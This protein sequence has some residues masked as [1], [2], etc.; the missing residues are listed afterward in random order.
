MRKE[1]EIEYPG[2]FPPGFFDNVGKGGASYSILH[3]QFSGLHPEVESGVLRT[4][5]KTAG[6]EKP[7][8]AM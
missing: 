1:A 2:G 5:I 7:S 8:A 3:S 4:V 6:N